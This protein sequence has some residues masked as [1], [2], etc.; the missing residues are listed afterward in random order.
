[1]LYWSHIIGIIVGIIFNATFAHTK[2]F[3]GAIKLVPSDYRTLTPDLQKLNYLRTTEPLFRTYEP[4]DYRT[5]KTEMC[6]SRHRTYEPSDLRTSGM[7][8]PLFRTYEPSD[9][10]T[11]GLES[12]HPFNQS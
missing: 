8:N 6:K 3:D 7:K 1:M 9:Y 12:S 4:S 10:R 11:F 5:F 2:S